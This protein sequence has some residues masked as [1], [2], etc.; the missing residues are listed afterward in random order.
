MFFRS[1]NSNV[2]GKLKRAE[3]VIIWFFAVAV[4]V[5]AFLQRVVPEFFFYKMLYKLFS[6]MTICKKNQLIPI[7]IFEVHVRKTY[8]I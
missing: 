2:G 3:I 8:I 6:K 4:F 5:F 7:S 1:L